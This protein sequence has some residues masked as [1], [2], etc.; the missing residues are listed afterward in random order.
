[1][2]YWYRRIIISHIR[3]DF[4]WSVCLVWDYIALR[5]VEKK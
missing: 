4:I 1:M 5:E 2:P 3:Q